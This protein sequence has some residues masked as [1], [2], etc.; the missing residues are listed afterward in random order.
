ML[1]IVSKKCRRLLRIG[2]VHDLRWNLPSVHSCFI[3]A[4]FSQIGIAFARTSTCAHLA[5]AQDLT[6]VVEFAGIH[7]QV[8]ILVVKRMC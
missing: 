2:A 8:V 4:G 6:A 1:V 3:V 5:F 7:R